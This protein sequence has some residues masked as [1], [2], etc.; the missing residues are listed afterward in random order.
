MKRHVLFLL[1]FL[2]PLAV[3]ADALPSAPYVQVSG[4]GTLTVVPDMVHVTLTV[5]KT[6]KNL[7]AARADV[8]RRVGQIIGSAKKLG[9]PERDINAATISVWPQYQWQDNTQVFV[10]QHVSRRIEIILR[11]MSRY[12]DLVSALIKAGVTNIGSTTLDRSDMPA[13]RRQALAK[14]VDDA[15][16][17]ATA[18]TA[19]AGVSL[20]S[21]YSITENTGFTRPQPVMMAA[22]MAPAGEAKYEPG[23]I[24]VTA[25]VGIVYL[26]NKAH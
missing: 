22:K 5:E 6:D 13:L 17:R 11:D 18:L 20:G 1:L 8:E 16:A 15:H 7:A 12:A 19:A 10:G 4:H 21:V 3:L 9:I 14:A 26:L 2:L 24:E 25:D 23:T